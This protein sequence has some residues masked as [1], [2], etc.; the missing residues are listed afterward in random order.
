MNENEY[1]EHYEVFSALQL[2]LPKHYRVIGYAPLRTLTLLG[3]DRDQ[4]P[5][6]LAQE[7]FTANEWAFLM[8]LLRAYP[9]SVGYEQFQAILHEF[10]W[11]QRQW[12]QRRD[13]QQ[14]PDLRKVRN[15]IS[16]IRTKLMSFPLTLT[17]QQEIGYVVT[18]ATALSDDTGKSPR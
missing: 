16:S 3:N 13:R 1:P 11:Q 15:I 12:P 9:V 17:V 14:P 7:R 6:V 5:E 10:P 4:R 18:V 8:L 2:A